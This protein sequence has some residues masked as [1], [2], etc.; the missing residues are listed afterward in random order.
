MDIKEALSLAIAI[1]GHYLELSSQRGFPINLEDL[2][3][4]VKN[5]H[6]LKEIEILSV[7]SPKKPIRSLLKRYANRATIYYPQ[8]LNNCH[9]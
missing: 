8:G 7:N 4:T 1:K 9:Q 5:Y 2:T 6:E 3:E